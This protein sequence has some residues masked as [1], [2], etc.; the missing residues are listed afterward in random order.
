[1]TS[2]SHVIQ[3]RLLPL[4]RTGLLVQHYFR[5]A[6]DS[7]INALEQHQCFAKRTASPPPLLISCLPALARPTHTRR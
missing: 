5:F 3:E 7:A 2:D 4:L 1:M 6:C